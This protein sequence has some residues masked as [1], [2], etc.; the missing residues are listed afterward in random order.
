MLLFFGCHGTE[1]LTGEPLPTAED[2]DT[3]DTSTP[4][5]T[6]GGQWDLDG[7]GVNDSDLAVT[8]CPDGGTCLVIASAVVGD[9]EVRL[10][11][12]EPFCDG[13]VMGP[14]IELA[15]DTSGDGVA[16]VAAGYCYVADTER[17][18]ALAVVDPA[19]ALVVA[20]ARAPATANHAWIDHPLGPEELRRPMLAPSYGD[21][22]WGRVCVY[23]PDLPD[24]PA[25]GTGFSGVAV[26]SVEAFREVGGTLQDLDGDGWEDAALLYHQRSI[27]ISPET[28]AVVSDLTYDVALATEPASPEWFHSGRNYGTHAAHTGADG[29]LRTTIVG[30]VPVGSFTDTNCNVSRFVAGLDSTAAQ[31]TTRRLAWSSYHGFAS[32]IF[33]AYDA[34][35][36]ADPYA[37]VSRPADIMDGCLHRFADGLTTMDGSEAL[38]VSYFAQNSPVD[39]CV[40][41]QYQLYLEPT[42]TDEKADAWYGCFGQNVGAMGKW[43]MQVYRRSDGLPLT[44]SLETYVWGWSDALLPSGERVYLVE[45]LAGEG[46]FDLTDRAATAMNVW[47]LVDGLWT[48]RGVFPVAGRPALGWESARGATGV[49]SYTALAQLV[50]SDADGDGL[51]DVQ[52]EDGTLV[53]WDGSAF[54]VR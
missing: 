25:C 22:S 7:D 50:T 16:E 33:S 45:Y 39:D 34:A 44:G 18:P 1:L 47:A 12:A 8:T 11:E 27:V 31:V 46:R 37:V 54:A 2:S 23:R 21:D 10:A 15:G 5:T 9:A 4:T 13:T 36:A 6:V 35:Y 32:T 49:G 28:L 14:M 26:P 43:G 41:E 20:E 38:I 17:P 3:R 48:A 24:D 53:G 42:W 30:G 19:L 51:V 40:W 52:L 29:T